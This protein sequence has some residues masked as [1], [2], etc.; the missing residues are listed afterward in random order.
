MIAVPSLKAP[1]MIVLELVVSKRLL[2]VLLYL[3][4][5]YHPLSVV[6]PNLQSVRRKQ[7]NNIRLTPK[8]LYLTSYLLSILLIK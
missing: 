3:Q 5:F 1:F 6:I 8:L 7:G 2:L 4:S